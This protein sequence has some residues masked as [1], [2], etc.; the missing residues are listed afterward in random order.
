MSKLHWSWAHFFT[1]GALFRSNN[2]F[3]NAWCIACLDHH[4]ELLRKSDVLGTAMSGT[5]SDCTDADREA[6][7]KS[8]LICCDQVTESVA[9][10]LQR[11]SIARR[12]QANL[13]SQWY[14]I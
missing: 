5:S 7:G 1:D 13:V 9:N 11:V 2:T 4:K 14:R 10:F 12:S 3:K 6:Q 8:S